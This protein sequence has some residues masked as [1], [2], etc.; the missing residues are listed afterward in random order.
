MLAFD[1]CNDVICVHPI[2][3]QTPQS[4]NEDGHVEAL[5]NSP[6]SAPR[7]GKR[8]GPWGRAYMKPKALI[9]KHHPDP[10]TFKTA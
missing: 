7:R 5:A 9:L 10:T 3:G 8:F 4:T 2:P 6:S 1:K